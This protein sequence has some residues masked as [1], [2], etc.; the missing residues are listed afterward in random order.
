MPAALAV[1]DSGAASEPAEERKGEPAGSQ[2]SGHVATEAAPPSGFSPLQDHSAA[3][4]VYDPFAH[5]K[6]SEETESS[7]QAT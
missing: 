5:M 3:V 1:A 2:S 7:N 6:V 4:A